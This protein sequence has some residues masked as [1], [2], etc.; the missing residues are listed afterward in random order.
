MPVIRLRI[1]EKI[2][3]KLIAVLSKFRK[4]DVE[5]IIEDQHFQKNQKY[6]HSELEQIKEGNAI[7]LDIDQVEEKLEKI[8]S[9]DEDHF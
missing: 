5:V 9:Q 1:N 6:L 7:F 3:N 2:Y 4:E 8:I